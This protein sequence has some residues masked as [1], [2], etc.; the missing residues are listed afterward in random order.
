MQDDDVTNK[1]GIYSFVLDGKEKHLNIRGFSDNMKRE[2]YERQQGICPVCN[3]HFE[4][5]EMEGDHINP[6][7]SGRK[8][9]AANCR[10]LCKEYNRRKSGK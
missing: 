7:H 8:T 5:Q 2:A 10:M 6:W 1:K 3:K 9:N 4:M